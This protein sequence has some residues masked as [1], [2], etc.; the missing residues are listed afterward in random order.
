MHTMDMFWSKAHSFMKMVAI[1]CGVR[2]LLY[3]Q[4][5]HFYS[6]EQW[7]IFFSQNQINQLDCQLVQQAVKW[8]R[9][10]CANNTHRMNLTFQ[11]FI[12]VMRLCVC[13]SA[14]NHK[15]LKTITVCFYETGKIK[16]CT[17]FTNQT[18]MFS[19]T[20]ILFF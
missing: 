11:C 4:F 18:I 13:M 2:S 20:I 17:Y 8:L 6:F 3:F 5:I 10:E 15:T 1:S 16:C 19:R 14:Y 9:M 12:W 7:R